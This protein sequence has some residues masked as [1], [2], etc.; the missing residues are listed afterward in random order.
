[1]GNTQPSFVSLEGFVDAMVLVDALRGAGSSPTREKLVAA[2]ENT[3]RKDIG[4]GP[5]LLL[6]F[7]PTSH[8]G[9]DS[10]YVTVIRNGRPEVVNNW[11][12]LPKD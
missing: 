12:E 4:L 2:L 3:R 9:L 5:N 11:K 1:M 8:K 10:V 7:S 6:S